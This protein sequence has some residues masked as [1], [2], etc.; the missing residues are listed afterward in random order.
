MVKPVNKS[1]N[2]I[3]GYIIDTLL[4]GMSTIDAYRLHFNVDESV[5]DEA[6]AG[7]LRT[8]RKS[9]L[10]QRME[11]AIT[12]GFDSVL[13]EKAEAAATDYMECYSNLLRKT[14]EFIDTSDGAEKLK[15]IAAQR[16]NINNNP[17]ET[18]KTLLKQ[19]DTPQ[20]GDG[21]VKVID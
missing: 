11:T 1:A 13:S 2:S 9:E 16:E 17:F 10:Y 15:A 4:N 21:N 3:R 8:L 14:D 7:R 6:I 18:F 19:D 20:I 5:S 12:N